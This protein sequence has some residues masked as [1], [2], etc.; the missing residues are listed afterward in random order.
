VAADE[1]SLEQLALDHYVER[2]ISRREFLATRDLLEER[3]SKNRNAVQQTT[4]VHALT[5]LPRTHKDLE[6]VWGTL[7]I[8]RQRAVLKAV[9][10][11]VIVRPGTR[12]R[13]SFDP[14]RMEIRWRV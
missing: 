2:V 14:S 5:G 11:E 4:N 8:E 6:A 1:S 7:D 10:E 9:V 12:G 13:R 3:I